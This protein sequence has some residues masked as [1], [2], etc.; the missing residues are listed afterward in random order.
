VLEKLDGVQIAA[1][2][3]RE[4]K[5]L[6]KS[7]PLELISIEQDGPGGSCAD[8]L[9]YGPFSK[10]LLSIHTGA[11]LGDG[12]NY[13]LRAYL[14]AE[15]KSYL[16]EELPVLPRDE[17]FRTQAT[18]LQFSFKS[19]L[20]LIESKEDYRSRFSGGRTRVEKASGKSPD[21]WDA[22]VLTFAPPRAKPISKVRENTAQIKA[23]H[24]RPLDR[25]M[26]Y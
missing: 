4:A 13:N 23:S 21:R 8:Q 9:R 16:E 12:H 1:I 25:A 10:V 11:R 7:A 19:G 6:L 18:A 24:W 14:H 26:G 5:Q 3:E 20:L 2:V 22:F 15:A 17:I